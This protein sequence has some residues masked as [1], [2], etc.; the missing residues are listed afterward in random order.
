MPVDCVLRQ[1]G[2]ILANADALETLVAGPRPANDDGLGFRRWV[3]TRDL[4]LHFAKMEGQVYGPLMEE[5]GGEAARFASRASAETA[6]LVADFRE[7]VARW[8]GFPSEAQ[9]ETYARSI[10]WL[11][12]RIRERL[13][14]EAID[15]VPLLAQLPSTDDDESRRK[16]DHRYVADAWEIRE[17][18]FASGPG[19]EGARRDEP[20][21]A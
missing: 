8:H 21:A 16:P 7:H 20:D 15:I 17:L 14:G 5:V 1:H 6:A 12:T 11:M 2:H 18:I 10:R 19:T 13:E 3:F 4:L 9:W